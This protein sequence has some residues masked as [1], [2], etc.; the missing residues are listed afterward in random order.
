MA[1]G[2]RGRGNRGRGGR[3]TRGSGRGGHSAE[4]S[5][6]IENELDFNIQMYAD[7][8]NASGGTRG[9]SGKNRRGGRGGQTSATPTRGRGRGRGGYDSPKRGY[10]SPAGRGRGRGEAF[11]PSRRGDYGIG[12]SPRGRGQGGFQP[13][14]VTLSGLL[15]QERPLLR[16]IVFVPSVLTKVLFEEEEELIKPG[17]EDVDDTEQSH[18]PTAN[19]VARVFG[20]ADAESEDEE[21]D[22]EEIEEIDFNQMDKLFDDGAMTKTTTTIKKSKLAETATIFE[23][24]FTGFYVDPNPSSKP[25]EVDDLARMMEE[26]LSAAEDLDVP[27]EAKVPLEDTTPAATAANDAPADMFYIDVEPAQVPEAIDPSDAPRPPALHDDED[28]DVIV[29]VAP[30]PRKGDE[31][32]QKEFVAEEPATGVKDTSLFTPYVSASAFPLAAAS[33]FMTTSTPSTIPP[34]PEAPSFSAFS[35]SF[36]KSSTTPITPGKARLVV[37]PVS[38]PRQAKAW[39]K[40]RGLGKKKGK[41]SFGAFGAMLEEEQLHQQDP[42]RSQRRRGDSDLEWGDTDDENV[43]ADEVQ[44]GLEDFIGLPAVNKKGRERHLAQDKGKGKA[45]ASDD[46]HGMDV[47]PDLAS[48]LDAMRSFAEGLIGQKAGVHETID[49]VMDEAMLR[50]EDEDDDGGTQSSEDEEE[51]DVLAVE[52]AMLISETLQFDDGQPEGD[53]E[54]SDDDDGDSDD[55]EDQTPRTSFEA[56]LQRLRE[57]SRSKKHADTSMEFMPDD[58]DEDDFVQRNMTWADEDEDFIQEIQDILDDNEAVLTG[59]DRKAQHALFRSIYNG[60]FDDYADMSPAKRRKDKGKDLPAD[61]KAQWEK[62]RK[63]KAERKKA[64]ELAR[65]EGA[66]DPMSK[67]KG[68]KK[69]RKAMLVAASLDPTITVI[70]N[71]VI[72][73]VTLT[74]QIRRFIAEIGG[75]K[76]MSLPPTTKDT[77]KKIHEMAAAFNLKSVSKGKG[78]ARYTTL[79]KTSRTG[80][81]VDEKKVAWIAQQSGARGEFIYNKG[82]APPTSMPRHREGDEVGKAAPKLTESNIGFRMLALM[83]WQEGD[84]IGFTNGL[85][86]PL[87]AIIKTT[88]LGLGAT[89]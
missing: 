45:K 80:Q 41:S 37:P 67:K 50:M 21:E 69:G 29:Y 59:R 34:V 2:G 39:K 1:R 87:T 7:A 30:H 73:M 89:K 42:R 72:D 16:P 44:A 57:K 12:A 84:R 40:K 77:R 75:P 38:T 36:S 82:R 26:T 51:E 47:D 8:P 88:K 62:D 43:D 27:I 56:R 32:S 63:V 74:Q 79:H 48:D 15:Y 13:K 23:E 58:S 24:Q 46:D 22:G 20:V 71:R 18:V 85:D 64:R 76:Q 86:A 3:G 61:L 55:D 35:F 83:G 31:Q 10:E 25:D 33:T 19:R 9:G 5:R 81:R 60:E 49:D 70:P 6:F 66:A 78:D 54:D 17:V 68:G 4:S 52:E 11:T 28:D 65:L 53:S 14:P